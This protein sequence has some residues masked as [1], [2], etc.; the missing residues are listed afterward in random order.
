[1]D[2]SAYLR[3][4]DYHGSA[5]PTAETLRA[6]H[7]AHLLS[8]PFEN[9]DIV[10]G[11]PIVL[12]PDVVFRK[13][14]ERRR[15]GYCYELNG[16]FA[17][18][19]RDLGFRVDLLSARVAKDQGGFGPEFDHMVLLVRLEGP[20]LA[21]VGFGDLFR[22]PLRLDEAGEQ[23]EGE[24]S[25]RIGAE[26]SHRVL[27]GRKGAGE[28]KP[29]YI[30]TLQRRRL[31]DYTSMNHYQQ[32]SPESSFTQKRVCSRATPEGRITL[33]DMRLIVTTHGERRERL[34]TSEEEVAAALREHFAIELDRAIP[35]PAA[36]RGTP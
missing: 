4:I 17:A 14:V 1:V 10:L 25:F 6:L 9:L 11:R 33:S 12:D 23:G 31:D 19:L 24:Q 35:S 34:L 16:L 13:I 20:W 29:T 18:L 3:R 21:D 36:V 15:G 30:F 5:E 28:W 22:A 27:W 2:V 32:T 7:E 8:V 26:G